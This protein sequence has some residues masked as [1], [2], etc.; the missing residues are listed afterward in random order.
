M[1]S[2]F[3]TGMP[4]CARRSALDCHIPQDHANLVL[5]PCNIAAA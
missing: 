4:L 3:A 1:G 2:N 5:Q